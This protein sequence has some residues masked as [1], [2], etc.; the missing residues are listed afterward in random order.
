MPEF[1]PVADRLEAHESSQGMVI[2]QPDATIA[3]IPVHVFGLLFRPAD[4]PK[5][6]PAPAKP[7]RVGTKRGAKTA[8]V[9]KAKPGKRGRRARMTEDQVREILRRLANGESLT[10]IAAAVGVGYDSVWRLNWRSK[11]KAP[12]GRPAEATAAKRPRQG[13]P[14]PTSYRCPECGKRTPTN[15][16]THCHLRW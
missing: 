7:A 5:A 2:V 6:L 4:A 16:C 12:K 15:P 3:L 10:A 9:K 11:Q 8:G 14:A 13:D 1:I